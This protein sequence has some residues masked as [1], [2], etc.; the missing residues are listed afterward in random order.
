MLALG[1]TPQSL[2]SG[3]QWVVGEEVRERWI[4]WPWMNVTWLT[5]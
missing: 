5:K 2:Q 4:A 1:G 3:A